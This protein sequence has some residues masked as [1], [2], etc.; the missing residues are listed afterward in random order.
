[1]YSA[2]RALAWMGEGDQHEDAYHEHDEVFHQPAVEEG[3]LVVG[4]EDVVYGVDEVG[5]HEAGGDEGPA[6]A[7]PAQVG[8][9]PGDDLDPFEE[10]RIHPGEEFVGQDVEAAD[11]DL[12]APQDLGGEEDKKPH[13]R[14]GA[15]ERKIGRTGC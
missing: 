4:P 9:I 12:L 5:E 2:K 11:G 10:Q 3:F 1:M 13:Q 7:E 14:D 8:H 15:E 6:Q